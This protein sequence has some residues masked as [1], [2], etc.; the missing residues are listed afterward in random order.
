[1]A[2]KS[3]YICKSEKVAPLRTV[4]GFAV[5][6]C[7]SCGL[8]WVDDVAHD[9]VAAIYDKGYFKSGSEIG[10]NDYLKDETNH[11]RNARGIIRAVSRIRD[12]AGSRI[13]DVGAAFGFF[14]DEARRLKRCDVHGVEISRHACEYAGN[15]LRLPVRNC[16]IVDAGFGAGSFDA[17]FMIGT[18]E[19]LASPRETVSLIRGL[20]K[21]DGVLVITTVDTG[22]LLPV[23]AIK[24]P[25]HLFYFNQPN[26]RRFLG[27]LGF[28][29]ISGGT[30][31]CNYGIHDLCHRLGVF[32]RAPFLRDLAS[33]LETKKPAACIT[34]PTNEMIVIARKR[35][36]E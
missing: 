4:N 36:A 33:L 7:G 14:L 31:F 11:R 3:C 10:Y 1:M 15:V 12:L 35:G 5:Y 17:V 21:P 13:L 2:G 22:G 28:D 19:H 16:Q 34:I 27:S 26:I 6:R 23:Y 8:K 32:F 9:R 30:Y 25:E 24:P 18:I 29:V 20:L